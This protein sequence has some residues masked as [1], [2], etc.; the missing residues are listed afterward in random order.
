MKEITK[1][2]LNSAADDLKIIAKIID[3]ETLTHQI[4]FHAQQTIEKSLKALVDEY[5]IGLIRTHSLE[6]LIAKTNKHFKFKIDS[7]IIKKL[8][9]LYID[10]RYPG[11][12]GLLPNGKPGI[13]E[14]LLFQQAAKGIYDKVCKH[15]K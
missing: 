6:T 14:A 9:Q 2:W 12:F 10:A 3:D 4:A 7:T 5:E 13:S 15:L 8:D 11:D 1:D